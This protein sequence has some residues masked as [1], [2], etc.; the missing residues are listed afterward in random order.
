MAVIAVQFGQCGNQIGYDLYKVICNDLQATGHG[1]SGVTNSGYVNINADKFF[2]TSS[3]EDGKL[4]SRC[5]LVDTEKKVLRDVTC[6]NAGLSFAYDPANVVSGCGGSA[7]NWAFGHQYKGPKLSEMA[8]DK[9]R[10]ETERCD[11]IYTIL[12]L[13]STAGGTGSGV[14]SHIL[15]CVRDEYPRKTLASVVVLP[16]S[17][18]EVA[19]QSYN[20]LFTTSNLLELSDSIVVYCNEYLH[21]L[22][23]SQLK[24]QD[25]SLYDLNALAMRQLSSLFLFSGDIYGVLTDLIPHP[26]HK[27]VTLESAPNIPR[28]S[29]EFEAAIDWTMLAKEAKRFIQN[30][31][32]TEH[33]G[34]KMTTLANVV[35]TRGPGAG[36][37]CVF[38]Q[39]RKIVSFPK[40]L[41]R[42]SHVKTY[43]DDRRF[44]N[45]DKYFTWATNS[46]DIYWPLKCN[47]D[48]AYKLYS[49]RAYVHQYKAY[50]VKEE[51]FLEAFTKTESV[52]KAYKE[53]MPT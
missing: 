23:C 37:D 51:D 42:D 7:N 31:R 11:T 28:N 4:I 6:N 35:I 52:L 13:L 8:L 3:K 44:L 38:D 33:K 34:S 12:G 50:K 46:S 30:R 18:G 45:F 1:V 40:W 2:R 20:T 14:G 41:P 9:I 36:N 21:H 19:V 24:I 47:L 26:M 49:Y 25:T 32:L 39:F 17:Q 48:K 22:C 10:K 15:E 53:I 43:H 16:F 29:L 5:V 27:F